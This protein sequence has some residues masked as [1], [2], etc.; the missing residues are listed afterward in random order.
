MS[1]VALYD[2]LLQTQ[3]VVHCLLQALMLD[4]AAGAAART[5]GN[6]IELQGV[7]CLCMAFS[8]MHATGAHVAHITAACSAAATA[9]AHLFLPYVHSTR[10]SIASHLACLR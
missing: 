1:K 7:G 2:W 4:H 8:E 9:A 6:G 10:Q 5:C 3:L